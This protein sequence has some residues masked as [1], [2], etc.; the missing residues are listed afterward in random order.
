[1]DDPT[2]EQTFSCVKCNGTD[3]E[4]GEI[5]TTGAGFSRYMNLQ[6][7]KFGYVACKKCGYTDFYRD[8]G[9]DKGWKSV[10]DV[11]TN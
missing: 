8:F 7:H 9:K 2:G 6:N 3:H 11:L 5:R 10:L 4:T 1:M